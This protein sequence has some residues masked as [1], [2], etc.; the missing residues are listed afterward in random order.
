MDAQQQSDR[1]P[2]RVAPTTFAENETIRTHEQ[3]RDLQAR[4]G[5][6]TTINIHGVKYDSA[7]EVAS[8]LSFAMARQRK[9]S[10]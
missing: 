4:L 9:S 1:G 5:D 8:Q 6:G 10:S 2:G 3:E 7:G